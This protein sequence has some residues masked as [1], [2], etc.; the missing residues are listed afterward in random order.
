MLIDEA[1]GTHA[2]LA[3]RVGTAESYISQL[4]TARRG[5]ARKFCER[6][7]RAMNKPDGWMDQ[8]LPDESLPNCTTHE[9]LNATERRLLDTWRRISADDEKSDDG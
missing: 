2:A 8:W 4:K 3:E 7:E 6:L 5:I 1:G 9:Q